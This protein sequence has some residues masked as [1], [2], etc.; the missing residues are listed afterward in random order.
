MIVSDTNVVSEMISKA[1]DEK[2]KSWLSKLK[3]QDVYISAPTIME[4]RS[5]AMRLPLGK[6]R[7]ELEEKI[8][9]IS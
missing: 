2:V 3:S 6:R 5:G 1:P 8:I 4:L 7:Q 9:L